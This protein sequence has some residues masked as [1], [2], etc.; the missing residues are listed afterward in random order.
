MIN[1]VNIIVDK[2]T[3]VVT[4]YSNIGV[5]NI[6]QITNSYVNNIVFTTIDKIDQDNRDRVF[7]DLCNKLS[8]GGSMTVKFLNPEALAHKIKNGN[9]SG[10]TFSSLV[11]NLKSSWMETD[12]LGLMSSLRGFVLSK[13]VHEDVYSIAVIEKS[14]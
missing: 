12:F 1:Q 14:K 5:E 7:M 11:H 4:G 8:R 10:D 6:P 3:D 2:E 9:V 13:H